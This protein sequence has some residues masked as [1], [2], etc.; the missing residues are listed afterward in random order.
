VKAIINLYESQKEARAMW[1]TEEFAEVLKEYPDGGTL[2]TRS[3]RTVRYLRVLRPAP[4]AVVAV[5]TEIA[6]GKIVRSEVQLFVQTSEKTQ[7]SEFP[8]PSKTPEFLNSLCAASALDL[9]DRNLRPTVTNFLLNADETL[10][11]T[12]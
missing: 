4:K 11:T 3:H 7:V 10:M 2:W 6:G 5:M 9:L 1:T 12:W 8:N